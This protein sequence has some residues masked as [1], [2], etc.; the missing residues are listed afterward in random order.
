MKVTFSFR[1]KPVVL[2]CIEDTIALQPTSQV[3]ENA[4]RA[5]AVRRFGGAAVD[6]ASGGSIGLSVSGNDRKLFEKAGWLFTESSGSLT[7]AAMTR[8]AVEGAETVR[9]VFVARGGSTLIGTELVTVQFA[10]GLPRNEIRQLLR[11]HQ[12]TMVRMLGFAPNLYEV[13]LNSRRPYL[14]FIEKLQGSSDFLFAEPTLLEAIIPRHHPADP[15]YSQQWQHLNDGSNG[16]TR[17]A[18]IRSEAAW[19]L[20][21]GAGTRIAVVDN[22]MQVSHPDLKSAIKTGAYYQS[23][24]QGGATCIQYVP[25]T[26][27]F[28]SGSHGTFCMGMAGARMNNK[29]GCGSAPES[30][31]IP[32][33]CLTDQIGSQ[34][35]LA[36]AIAY[37]ANPQTEIAAAN[38]ADGADVIACSLGPSG[39][40]VWQMTSVL[41]LAIRHAANQGRNGLGVPIFWAVSNGY[42]DISEDEV[43]SHPDVIAVGRSNRN[44]LDDGSAYGSKLEF[45]APGREVYS[46]MQGSKYGTDTGTSY[47]CPLSAGIAALVLARYPA[48]TRDQVRQRLQDCCDK[49]GGVAYNA[50]GKHDEY[51]YGRINAE[52][53]V[54]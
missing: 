24:G 37:A 13:R 9:P 20:T 48:W 28:P 29:G 19:D 51:G 2:S 8:R 41:E 25:G 17:A 35:T 4:T 16:G 34:V 27:G 30:E 38:A 54:R 44:D 45:L 39:A 26:S 43:C 23:D 6:D 10:P 40:G 1:G 31:L 49:I 52:Q 42:H 3:M 53:A 50:A 15:G 11:Q 21:M 36:R 46:T 7:N 22:G 14:E 12:L 18:D 33:A 47:A 32:V 5:A